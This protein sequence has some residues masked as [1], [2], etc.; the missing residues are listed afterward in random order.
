MVSR[1]PP[2]ATRPASLIA[3]RRLAD[4]PK[5]GFRAVSGLI[6]A[7]FVTSVA[8]GVITTIVDYR[9]APSTGPAAH[10]LA[11]LEPSGRTVPAA[12]ES[13]P[14]VNAAVTI[15]LAPEARP[16]TTGGSLPGWTPDGLVACAALAGHPDFGFPLSWCFTEGDGRVFST[17]LG[18]FPGAWESP[19]YLQH[20][21]GGLAWALGEGK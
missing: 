21:A 18:H 14:G 19:V 16:L 8:V 10:N 17:S 9:S 13:V 20:L 11:Q 4:N 2:R 5:A 6:L 12:V 7:L 3:A 1:R 15:Y